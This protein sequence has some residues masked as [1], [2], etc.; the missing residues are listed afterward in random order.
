MSPKIHRVSGSL[1]AVNSYLV[2]GAKGVVVVDG[3]LTL[4]DARA[5]RRALDDIGKPA[6][7]GIVTHAHPDHYAGFAEIFRGLDVPIYATPAVRGVIERDDAV[8]NGIVGPMMGEEWPKTRVFPSHEVQTGSELR[9]FDLR[10]EVHD[11]GPAE[12]PADAIWKLDE[13]TLFVGD[14][15]YSGMHAY[16]ADGYA[17]EWLSCLEALDRTMAWDA[18]L[19]PGHGTPGGAPLITAQQRYVQAFVA[20]VERH[21]TQPA[22]ERRAAVV[23]EMKDLLGTEDLKFLMELSVDPFAAKL[24]GAQK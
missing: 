7:A 24:E 19:Y 3:M 20:A 4:S 6:L 15:V 9:L 11:V 16:L 10:F 23:A 8:K 14:L 13:R 1:M 2:E 12:S 18:T 17:T 21:L 5:V 22:A